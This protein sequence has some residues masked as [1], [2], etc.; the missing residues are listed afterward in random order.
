MYI[1]LVQRAWARTQSN[2]PWVSTFEL[3]WSYPSVLVLLMW[4]PLTRTFRMPK[5]GYRGS[6]TVNTASPSERLWGRRG[7]CGAGALHE[8]PPRYPTTTPGCVQGKRRACWVWFSIARI[9]QVPALERGVSRSRMELSRGGS[10][11]FFTMVFLCG[12]W[13]CART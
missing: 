10:G 5:V 12:N 4:E 2:N 3:R 7:C 9:E 13:S 11:R 1:L 6:R 8:H